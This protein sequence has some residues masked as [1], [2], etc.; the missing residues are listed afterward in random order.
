M[1]NSHTQS[2]TIYGSNIVVANYNLEATTLKIYFWK[3]QIHSVIKT[4]IE[5]RIVNRNKT[6]SLLQFIVF[7]MTLKSF[8][9][10]SK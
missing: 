10:K 8:V 9:N 5:N 2:K 1:H 4:Y 6:I 3:S 7:K